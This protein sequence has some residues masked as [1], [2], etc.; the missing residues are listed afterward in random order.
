MQAVQGIQTAVIRRQVVNGG[1]PAPVFKVAICT[2]GA[3]TRYPLQL[4][5]AGNQQVPDA[6]EK[7]ALNSLNGKMRHLHRRPG[8]CGGIHQTQNC[9]IIAFTK[10][11]FL[12]MQFNT[13]RFDLFYLPSSYF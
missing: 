12:Y 2:T 3:C 13:K 10:E 8:I 9:C 5:C 1:Q 6:E 7:A 11:N 4:E